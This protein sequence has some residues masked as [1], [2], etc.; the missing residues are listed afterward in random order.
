MLVE[1]DHLREQV[2]R[3][4]KD[5]KIIGRYMHEQEQEI[6]IKNTRL[7]SSALIELEKEEEVLDLEGDKEPLQ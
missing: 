2:I 7:F 6:A 4:D 3:K 1:F 5:L